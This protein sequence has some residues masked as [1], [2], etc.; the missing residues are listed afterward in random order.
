MSQSLALPATIAQTSTMLRWVALALILAP[1][2]V[3]AAPRAL[4]ASELEQLRCVAVLAIVA[5][6]Q[7]RGSAGWQDVPPLAARGAKYA[8]RVTEALIKAKVRTSAGVSADILAQI[9]A[10]QS[11]ASASG[12]A[13]SFLREK[14]GPC[15]ALLDA[16]IPP[17]QPPTLPQCAAA[18]AM[19]YE[20]EIK[21][22]GMTKS[23]RTLS[24]FAALLDRR[25]RDALQAEGKT[26]AES[27]VII[28]LEKEKLMAEFKARGGEGTLDRIDFPACFAMAQP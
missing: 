9:A 23:A 1:L 19:A 26:Q 6:E 4:A 14:S 2:P 17:A 3:R 25:A 15:I 7:Q 22:Q 5:N 20:D 12:D 16:A 21:N 28:G 27:D 18:L 10:L 13:A 11:E 24:I 8:D